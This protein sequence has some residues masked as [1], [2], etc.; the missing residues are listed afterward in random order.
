MYKNVIIKCFYTIDIN[1]INKQ[2]DD[3]IV[4]IY[5]EIHT[6]IYLL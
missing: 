6:N 1:V 5:N 2:Y 3:N 4:F